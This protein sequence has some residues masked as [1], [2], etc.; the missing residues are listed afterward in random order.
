MEEKIIVDSSVLPVN[1]AGP[2]EVMVLRGIALGGWWV[3]LGDRL[4]ASICLSEGVRSCT[5][6]RRS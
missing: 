4:Q 3:L 1:V 6:R 5:V 2:F